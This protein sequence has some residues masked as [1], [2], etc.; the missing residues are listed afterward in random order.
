MK[1]YAFVEWDLVRSTPLKH[2]YRCAWRDM[3][4]GNKT[5]QVVRYPRRRHITLEWD[6]KDAL[7]VRSG[8]LLPSKSRWTTD[9]LRSIVFGIREAEAGR[10]SSQSDPG[11]IWFIHLH[12]KSNVMRRRGVLAEFLVARQNNAPLNSRARIPARVQE[13]LNW[14][15]HC[16]GHRV[17]GPVL[18][19]DDASRKRI[20][21]QVD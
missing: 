4:L 3:L 19:T 10:R 17:H 8:M 7:T 5:Q 18:V 21:S 13:L 9:Q 12:G 6:G 2:T 11:W 15:G 16:T 20:L 1:Q 14:L